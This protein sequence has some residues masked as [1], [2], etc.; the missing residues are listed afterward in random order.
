MTDKQILVV[1]MRITHLVQIVH[2][3]LLSGF[4]AD[5]KSRKKSPIWEHFVVGE[6]DKF[7]L[8]RISVLHGGC[9]TRTYITNLVHH[10][11]AKHCEQYVEFEKALER[12]EENKGKGKAVLWQISL[13]ETSEQV[14]VWDIN[15][16]CAQQIHQ[17]VTEMIA[18]DSQPFYMHVLPNCLSSI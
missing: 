8:C 9:N 16:P 5:A 15:N 13:P 6:D 12:G 11:K 2:C 3:W 17:R 4:M 10:L 18:L 1:C 14:R 7:T